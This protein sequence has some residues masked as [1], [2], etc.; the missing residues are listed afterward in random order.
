MGYLWSSLAGLLIPVLVVMIGV[1]AVL[2]SAGGLSSGPVRLGTHL[3]VPVSEAFA[4]QTPL[5]QLTE[6]VAASFVI[7]ILFAFSVWLHRL[8][9]NRCTRGITKHL[10][11]RVLTQ[12]I[13]HAEVEGAAAQA[14]QAA[15]LIDEHLP[16]LGRGLSLWY[17]AIPRSVLTFFG[18]IAVALMVNVWL[19]MLAIVS[20]VIIWQL[21]TRL[22]RNDQ[23]E[24]INWEVPRARHRMAEL[25]GQAP[26]LARL[27]TQG[28]ADKAFE[29]ELE[30]MYR[31]TAE[32]ENR[33]A[34]IWPILF[35]ALA[36]AVAVIVLGLGVN[37][38]S[39]LSL[40]SALIIG[41]A[42]TGAAIA[43]GRLLTLGTQLAKSSEASNAVYQYLE[44]SNELSPSEQ[45]VGLMGLRD[46]VELQDVTLG[47]SSTRPILSNLTLKL[48][49][50]TL[51]A[52]LGTDSVSTRAIAEMLMGF[53]MPRQG[54]VTIDGIQIR[55]IHPAA[56][57]RN[58]MWI[59]PDGPVYDGTIQENL[60][61]SDDSVNSGDMVK[62]LE[63]VDVYERLIRLPEGLNTIVT[64]GDSML[65]VEATYAIG[66]ARAI[67]HKPAIILASEPPPPAE[68]LADDP[69]LSALQELREA[70][71]LVVILPRRL[72][73]L[74][75]ADRVVLLN[76]PRLAGE[77]KHSALVA[78]SDLYRHLNYLLF[79]PYR[80]GR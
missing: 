48:A 36:S 63:K 46:C 66:V 5:V 20:G 14:V 31:R 56:L 24:L 69:C 11:K 64:A 10:H 15:K 41:L 13:K 51:V 75:L 12:S 44:T 47:N 19:A 40:P 33:L 25:V 38:D 1:I 68:H 71:S 60:R 6:L 7:A 35:A 62:A 59:A 2:L 73:T 45:R 80:H 27:Q 79:N 16:E 67:L 52:L 72:Q 28:L 61:G 17:R 8:S 54:R 37:V 26:L 29:S 30:A 77:G 22:R 42:L 58:V 3:Y 50:K 23:S 9:V 70:G 55:D 65:G 32:E 49:P 78:D 43:A 39:G 34:R 76:G 57:A 4:G 21:F 74:R 53:G 18:C